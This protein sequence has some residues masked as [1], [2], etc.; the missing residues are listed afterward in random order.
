[1]SP[2]SPTLLITLFG[3]LSPRMSRRLESC[4]QHQDSRRESTTHPCC[5]NG[6]NTW[7]EAT[8]IVPRWNSWETGYKNKPKY[9]N[10]C[11]SNPKGA[12]GWMTGDS[13]RQRTGEETIHSVPSPLTTTRRA[14]NHV[15]LTTAS[16]WFSIAKRSTKES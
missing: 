10:C 1:M 15:R 8:L 14:P 5:L 13:H 9:T 3:R 12:E 7:L 11:P 4:K 2:P 16:T 6:M